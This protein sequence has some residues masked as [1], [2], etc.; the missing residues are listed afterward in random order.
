MTLH[1][2][3][4]GR[5]IFFAVGSGAAISFRCRCCL[6]TMK[7][8]STVAFALA[9]TASRSAAFAPLSRTYAFI[10]ARAHL[11]RGSPQCRPDASAN[12][13]N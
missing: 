6:S 13:Y 1:T 2:L 5:A 9:A 12:A 3:M 10:F 4:W 8:A 7:F 11:H